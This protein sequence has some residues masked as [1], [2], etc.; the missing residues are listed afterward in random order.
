MKQFKKKPDHRKKVTFLAIKNHQTIRETKAKQPLMNAQQPSHTESIKAVQTAKK[1]RGSKNQQSAKFSLKKYQDLLPSLSDMKKI[2]DM[3]FIDAISKNIDQDDAID[4]N[5]S[6]L[7]WLSYF[8]QVRQM[9]AMTYTSP[10]SR[11][12]RSTEVQ[13]KLEQFGSARMQ[14]I[15]TVAITIEKSG[16]MTEAKIVESSGDDQVDHFWLEILNITAPYP[17]LP[18]HYPKSNLK[19]TYTLSYDMIFANRSSNAW[20]NAKRPH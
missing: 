3:G 12:K 13:K 4:V 17:P 6:E 10:Y 20:T 5:T 19:F 16:V 18:K 15:C 2:A 11:L 14:G 8:T 9:V 1:L 7:K